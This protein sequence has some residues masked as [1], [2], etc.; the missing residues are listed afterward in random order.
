MSIGIVVVGPGLIGKKHISLI[1]ANSETH[2]VAIVAPD[3]PE[4]HITAVSAKVP[5]FHSLEQCVSLVKLDGVIVSSPNAFHYQ[6]ARYCIEKNIPVLIEKPITSD[7]EEAAILEKIALD[8]KAKVLVGHHRAYSPLL[9][10]ARKVIQEGRLGR[11][12]SVVGS[13]QFYKPTQ[14]FLDGPW[15]SQLGGGPILINMIHEVGNLRAL[16]G[17][18]IKVQAIA[19]SAVRQFEVEDTVVINFGFSNGALGT[20]VLSDTAATPM[21]WEQ[22]SRENPAYPSYED[23][24][25]YIVSGTLGCLNFPTM[26]IRYFANGNEA[27]WW[28][29]YLEERVSFERDDPLCRQLNHFVKLIQGQIEPQV[30]VV[31]GH[32]NLKVIEAIRCAISTGQLVSVGDL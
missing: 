19:S 30:S 6:Q 32:R 25:C 28:S 20:F 21:S 13:A 2:L 9:E 4:N 23:V 8:N 24:D 3:H 1:Q 15:R 22:T 26:K 18:I 10:T 16:M 27:S 29:P 11:L 14:Y 17:E 7:I 12:V 31:D 5:L